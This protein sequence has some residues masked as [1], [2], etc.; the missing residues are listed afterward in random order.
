MLPALDIL[1]QCP[2][3]RIRR[4]PFGS[5]LAFAFATGAGTEEWERARAARDLEP[6][7]FDPTCFA[8]GLGLTSFVERL[9]F[10]IEGRVH[11][12]QSKVMLQVLQSPPSDRASVDLRNGVLAEL[13]AQPGVHRAAE[14]TWVA[15]DGLEQTLLS[16]QLGQRLSFIHRRVEI[17]RR[18]VEAVESLAC[19]EQSQSALLRL[20][21]FAENV[22]AGQAYQ[23]LRRVLDQEDHLASVEVNLRLGYDGQLRQLAIVRVTENPNSVFRKTPLQ[24]LINR[25]QSWVRGFS[26][27]DS[28]VLGRMVEALFDSVQPLL[29]ELINLKLDLEWYL[30]ALDFKSRSAR[31]GLDVCLPQWIAPDE[32]GTQMTALFNPYLLNA[33]RPPVPCDITCTRDAL[34][35]ITGPNS[36]GKTRLLQSLGLAQLLAQTGFFVPARAARLAWRTGL[37]VS[38]FEESVVDQKE[39]RLGAELMR[40]RQVF[41]RLLPDELVILDELCSGTNP[42]EAEALIRLV[43]ELLARFGPQAFITTHFLEFARELSEAPIN[44]QLSFMQA[45]LDA[46]QKPTYQFVPGVAC[47]SL[48]AQTA[49][50]LGVTREDLEAVIARRLLRRAAE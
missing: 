1:N 27:R 38:S 43:L 23:D 40:I 2:K 35:V 39:G 29:I 32:T 16:K 4:E 50:R 6:T 48:A 36:G 13:V 26:L 37:F 46:R 12:P 24:R 5:L 33:E 25:V 34:V 31:S 14:A 3:Q 41:E 21:A 45:E 20:A 15:L 47:T 44:A 22:R 7:S 8:P 30:V 10:T 17:L 49:A 28:E 18:L 19:F 9:S 42:S 11:K